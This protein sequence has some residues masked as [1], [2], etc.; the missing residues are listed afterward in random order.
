MLDT[1]LADF[2]LDKDHCSIYPFGSGL[3][4]NNTWKIADG[5]KSYILQR[6]NDNVLRNRR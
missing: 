4:N 6:I 5:D 3:I 1:V 2:R